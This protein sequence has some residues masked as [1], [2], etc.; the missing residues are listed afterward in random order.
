MFSAEPFT[1]PPSLYNQLVATPW[2][3]WGMTN[4]E[5]KDYPVHEVVLM[6]QDRVL[7]R[8][9]DSLTLSRI[10][11][12]ELKVPAE[13]DAFTTAELI[14]RLTNAVTAEVGSIPPGEY[15]PRKPAISSMRRGLQGR[16]VSRMGDLALGSSGGPSDA[17]AVA[18]ESLRGLDGRITALLAKGDVKL[19]PYS[20]AHL[21]DMRERI[22]KVLEARLAMPRP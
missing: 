12:C 4:V 10:R 21:V 3:H 16:F 19:D 13:E 1:F 7:G 20:K 6:W 9:L 11:D 17:Q 5:R 18:A 2:Y 14:D 15:T 8:L 22:H